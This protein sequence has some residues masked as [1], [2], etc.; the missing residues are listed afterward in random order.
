MGQWDSTDQ[1]DTEPFGSLLPKCSESLAILLQH[2]Q[3][4]VSGQ[5]QY[6]R[7][8]IASNAKIIRQQ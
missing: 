6:A 8:Y 2:W 1:G 4:F 5:Y 7:L 3:L